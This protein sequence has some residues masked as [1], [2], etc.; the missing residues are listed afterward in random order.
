M[1]EK[2]NYFFKK[3]IQLIIV[4]FLAKGLGLVREMVLANYYGTSYVS[5]VFIAVQ[6]IPSIIFTIFGTAVTT[7]FIPIY[8]ELEVKKGKD[9]A[10]RFANNV[11]NIFLILSI[12][13]TLIGIIF[14]KQLVMIFAGGFEGETL[15]LCNT[16]AK[17]IM[18]TSIAI[19]LV[20]IYNAYLQI[21]GHFNQNSLMNVPYN[22]VQILFIALGFY[23][24]NAYILAL[25]LLLASYSQL[26]YLKIL[27]KK[28]TDFKHEK[29]VKFNDNDIKRMLILV[30]PLFISTGINQINSIIDKSLASGLVEGS[31][32]A[33]NYSAEISNI[34]TQVIILSLTTIL[35]PKMTKLFAENDKKEQNKFTTNYINIVSLIVFPL[36]MLI[37]IFAEEIV[38]ILFGRGAFTNETVIF[39]SRALRIY[40]VGIIG[41]SFR[42]VFNK[43]FYAMKNTV[44]PVVNGVISVLF[45]IVLNLILIGEYEYLGLAFATSFSSIT[46][47]I[48]MFIQLYR[49]MKN[50][51][52]KSVIIELVKSILATAIMTMAVILLKNYIIINN[53]IIRCIIFG[54][55]GI[56]SY[57]IALLIMR[58]K[59]IIEFIKNKVILKLSPMK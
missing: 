53:D 8:T 16:F 40:A 13:L 22:I 49:K 3:T 25:G 4:A 14:S 34:V 29:Y 32:S 45:N 17:I 1:E 47:T 41:A 7:G 54:G 38:Q 33:L 51:N 52:I 11:F 24:G 44:I 31:V 2:K 18:P 56:L 23:I 6:N 37:Y 59:Y 42:D 10:D 21:K 26:L 27:M 46:C 20:Y 58:E 36:T 57:F 55:F 9:K 35:Y 5:D 50:I 19:I 39:V 30:G 48:L 15:A 12:I 43:I 28:N